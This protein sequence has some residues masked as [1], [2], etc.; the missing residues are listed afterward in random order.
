MALL[1][2]YDL[3]TADADYSGLIEELKKKKVWWHYLKSTWIVETAETPDELYT[4]LEPHRHEGDR[5]LI[6]ELAPGAARQGW[7]PE[8]AWNWLEKRI[9]P[10]RESTR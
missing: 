10:E 8:K 9:G 5:L 3:R 6:L 4:R 1:V 7:L 2:S